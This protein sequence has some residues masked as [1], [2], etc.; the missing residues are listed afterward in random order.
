LQMDPSFEPARKLRDKTQNPAL[1]IDVDLLLTAASGGSALDAARQAM[2]ARD[3]QRVIQITTEILTDDL[4]N[5]DARILGDEA[6]EKLEASPF[7]DQ[8]VRKCDQLLS[9]GNFAAAKAEIEKARALDPTHPDIVRI[10]REIIAR[11]GMAAPTPSPAAPA[12]GGFSFD[13][14]PSPSFVVDDKAQ[15]PSSGRSA[16]QA[17]DFGF[18]FEEDKGASAGGFSS[19]SFDSPG[20]P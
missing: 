18:T 20:A 1:P 6:R 16:A 7:V 17:S 14:S 12:G 8:F 11:E 2:A 5:E 4:M 19:F 15:A 13:A 3:F 10:G 9:S